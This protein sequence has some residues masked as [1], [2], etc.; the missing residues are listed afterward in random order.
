MITDQKMQNHKRCIFVI[1]VSITLIFRQC[2]GQL[3]HLFC[4]FCSFL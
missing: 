1:L 2:D 3:C 4:N